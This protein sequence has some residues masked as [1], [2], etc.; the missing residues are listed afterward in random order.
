MKTISTTSSNAYNTSSFQLQ[1]LFCSL[2]SSSFKS[3]IVSSTVLWK[4]QTECQN[5]KKRIC[6]RLH[7]VAVKTIKWREHTSVW[8]LTEPYSLFIFHTVYTTHF[9][10]YSH[11]L[12]STDSPSSSLSL[13][14]TRG[15][16]YLT[17]LGWYM[18]L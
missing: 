16:L 15:K 9:S 8:H 10:Y 12:T 6:F 3:C 1:Y 11:L 7:L 14:E 2:T 5:K 18:R 13:K 17:C 4:G